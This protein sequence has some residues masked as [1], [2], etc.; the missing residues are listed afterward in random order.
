MR[1]RL[2]ERMRQVRRKDSERGAAIV[3]AIGVMIICISLGALIVSQAIATQR[4]S[5]R[6]RARTVEIHTAEGGVDSLFARMQEGDFVC[7]WETT[8]D[9]ALGPDE[10]GAEAE[11][12]YWDA[13]GNHMPCDGEVLQWADGSEGPPARVKILVT[14]DNK[15]PTMAGIEPVRSFESEILISENSISSEGAAVF[16][17]DGILTTNGASVTTLNEATGIGNIWVDSGNVNCNSSFTAEGSLFI[18][19]GKLDMSGNCNIQGDVWVSGSATLHSAPTRI[20][21]SLW[22]KTGPVTMESGTSVGEFVNTG[23]EF[24]C[25]N[26]SRGG[27]NSGKPIA[28]FHE[29]RGLPEVTFS[30]SDWDGFTE[31]N[32]YE[33]VRKSAVDNGANG[34]NSVAKSPAGK[35]HQCAQLAG[36][37]WSMNGPLRL[38][39]TNSILDARD[40]DFQSLDLEIVLRADTVIFAKSFLLG[41]GLNL[42]SEGGEHTLWLIVPDPNKNGVAECTGGIGNISTNTRVTTRPE[43][44]IFM[45]TP[46]TVELNNDGILYGQ[47]YGSPVNLRNAN[48]VVYVPIG[49]PGVDLMPGYVDASNGWNVD[50]IY[51]RETGDRVN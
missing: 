49:I 46:C 26:C 20:G 42:R 36:A 31:R 30:P 41:N 40:C 5:A 11:L 6:N 28:A 34:N 39:E 9:D 14:S 50:V 4:D 1:A 17:A 21:K 37:D 2:I 13:D 24:T 23:G 25:R 15:S 32:Y 33:V 38:P 35:Q 3:A 47:I 8:A 10:V 7:D 48:D 22:S 29:S 27:V 45:Y 51:K 19:N 16:S 18:P 12:R 44:S 43:A